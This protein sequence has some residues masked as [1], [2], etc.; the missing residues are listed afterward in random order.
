MKHRASRELY[1]YWNRVRGHAQAPRRSD[2]EPAGISGIL[3]DTFILESAARDRLP[4][5]LAG[6]RICSLYGREIRSGD[7]LALWSK[8]DREAITTLA[9]AVAVDAAAAV[10]SMEAVTRSGRRLPCEALLLPLIQSG[11]DFDRILGSCAPLEKPFWLGSDPIVAQNLSGFRLIWPDEHPAFMQ[12]SKNAKE[13]DGVTP[14]AIPP[15]TFKRRA[16]LTIF[17]GGKR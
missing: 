9:T 4:I 6:T 12:P 11:P 14:A 7:F 17:E 13:V 2:I 8:T 3:A 1:G 15:S 10:L 16:H 5:R